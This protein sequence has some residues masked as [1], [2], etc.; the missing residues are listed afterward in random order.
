MNIFWGDLTDVSARTLTLT[1]TY[2][3]LLAD[4]QYRWKAWEVKRRERGTGC[5]PQPGSIQASHRIFYPRARPHESTRSS[6][7]GVHVRCVHFMC[8][9][10][11]VYIVIFFTVFILNVVERSVVQNKHKPRFGSCKGKISLAHISRMR[12]KDK[13]SV[14]CKAIKGRVMRPDCSICIVPMK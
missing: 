14:L 10:T 11:V 7:R 1:L 4:K 2:D 3:V 6:T 5:V 8:S 13:S 9:R 12:H